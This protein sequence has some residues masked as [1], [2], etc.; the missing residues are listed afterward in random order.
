MQV[1]LEEF[2][3]QELFSINGAPELIAEMLE[4]E[5]PSAVISNLPLEVIEYVLGELGLTVR[6]TRGH[7]A[8]NREH[9]VC[10]GRLH[11]AQGCVR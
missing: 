7:L 9:W 1:V 2:K 10:T 8:C 6:Q 3:R 4:N 5:I 11:D